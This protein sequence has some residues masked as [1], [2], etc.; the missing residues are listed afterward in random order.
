MHSIKDIFFGHAITLS[1]YADNFF[2]IMRS[3]ISVKGYIEYI[4]GIK[5]E[6]N[7]K[8][9]SMIL[10]GLPVSKHSSYGYNKYGYSHYGKYGYGYGHGYGYG[11]GYGYS[12]DEDDDGNGKKEKTGFFK[13][14]FGKKKN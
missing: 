14:V 11:Y 1:K 5:E 2:Y 3:G 7:I 10:N 13:R 12:T 8:N 4:N 6:H 9:I